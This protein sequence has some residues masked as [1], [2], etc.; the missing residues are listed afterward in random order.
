MGETARILIVDDDENIRKVLTTI[1]E[2]E[3]YI[4]ESVGTAKKAIAKT[5][6]KFYNLAL[7][8]VRLPDMEGIELLTRMKATTPKMRKIIITGY[9]TLQNAVEAVNRGADAYI[10]KPFDMKK[11]LRTIREELTKQQEEKR[12]SQQKVA[13]FIETRVKELEVEKKLT[14][15]SKP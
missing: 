10:I 5:G 15:K 7:I 1:L 4:V 14:H 6:K 9:P 11:A 13:E 2:D 8:D 3:G 12:Y